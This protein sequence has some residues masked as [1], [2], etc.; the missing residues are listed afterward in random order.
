M[1][2]IDDALATAEAAVGTE[3]GVT[4]WIT[5]D[6]KMIDDFAEVTNDHQ[7]I[8]VDPER[9]AKETPFGTTIAHGFL[10]LSLGSGMAYAV[11][12]PMKG[13]AM[14][15]NY[16]FEKVRFLNPVKSGSRIRG[17]FVLKDVKKRK[18][19]EILRT[20]QFTVEIEGEDTPALVADWLGLTIFP[21]S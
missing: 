6:Q 18:P 11:A 10:T 13:Q 19:T 17:R 1:A 14:S 16:G 15:I 2:A 3:S 4:D 8:H 20:N 5:V 12:T 9:A 7:W 21:P